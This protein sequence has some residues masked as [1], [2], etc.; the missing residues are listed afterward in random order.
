[1]KL[2]YCLLIVSEAT[3]K[4]LK[5]QKKNLTL[6]EKVASRKFRVRISGF[7]INNILM[8]ADNYQYYITIHK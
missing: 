7:R 6:T 1:M 8:N 5:T 3:M 4:T 2:N